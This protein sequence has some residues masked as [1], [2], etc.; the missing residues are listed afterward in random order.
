MSAFV[1]TPDP[2]E[3][4]PR[5]LYLVRHAIAAE[6][7]EKYPDDRARPLTKTGATRMRRVA[8]GLAR[9]RPDIDLVLTSPLVRAHR[10]AEILLAALV[11]APRL[12]VLDE[13]APGHT[14]AEVAAALGRSAAHQ[15]IALVGHEP[16]LGALAAW[17]LGAREPLPFKKGS[18]ACVDVA[19]FPPG[20]TGRLRWF[21]TP[22]MLRAL[23]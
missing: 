14:P 16:D 1:R 10:T 21:A 11:P 7:G 9:L 15:A 5:T 8:A 17:L 19:A 3:A 6:R 18:I 2:T 4:L 20:R 12:E 13:L 22:R 23:E